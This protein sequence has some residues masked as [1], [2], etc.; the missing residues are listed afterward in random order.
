MSFTIDEGVFGLL[1]D[2]VKDPRG[3][4]DKEHTFTL[5]G[6][7]C[8]MSAQKELLRRRGFDVGQSNVY[9][10]LKEKDVDAALKVIWEMRCK[11]W[12][13]YRKEMVKF[14]ICSE[15]AWVEALNQE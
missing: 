5:R 4:R 15:E 6:D 7:L 10:C 8:S 13:H 9:P 11:G 14:N 3:E 12:W 2:A 1:Q